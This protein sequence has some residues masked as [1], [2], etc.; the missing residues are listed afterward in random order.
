MPSHRTYAQMT[1]EG[2]FLYN[3]PMIVSIY[4]PDGVGKSTFA[5]KLKLSLVEHSQTTFLFSG[6]HVNEWPDK[7]WYEHFVQNNIDESAI[8]EDSHFIEKILRCHRIASRFQ[9]KY[10]VVIIDSDPIHKTLI[11][12]FIRAEKQDKDAN[13]IMKE[14]FS[15]FEEL[16]SDEG[17]T[18]PQKAI[19][20]TLS[21]DLT[22]HGPILMS[23]LKQRGK[24][25]HFDPK[26]EQEAQKIS[27]AANEL[28]QLL[29]DSGHTIITIAADL[30]IDI[31][32]VS[33]QVLGMYN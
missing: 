13:R 2:L 6:T 29:S 24:L 20:I 3:K 25:A 12:D 17:L 21:S 30:P 1:R 22:E 18:I 10:D 11:H 8:E 31:E 19:Y 7:E 33:K 26:T 9:N 14:R 27:A 4:G 5:E 15:Q 16:L 23:R 28:N 32:L